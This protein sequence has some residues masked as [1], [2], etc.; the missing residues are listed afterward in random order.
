MKN[1][2]I[3]VAGAVIILSFIA[4]VGYAAGYSNAEIERAEVRHHTMDGRV[5]T[6]VMRDGTRVMIDANEPRDTSK[7]LMR[8]S[9]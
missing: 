5:V 2:I 7:P 4:W 3:N 9:D 6:I 1:N 8:Q